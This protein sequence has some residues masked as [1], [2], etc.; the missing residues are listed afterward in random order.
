LL[1][2]LGSHAG[3]SV[4]DLTVSTQDPC[5]KVKLAAVTALGRM[6][7]AAVPAIP[8][9][10]KRGLADGAP[11]VRV[12]TAKALLE[13]VHGDH[14]TLHRDLLVKA[15]ST[16]L[17]DGETDVRRA[18]AECLRILCPRDHKE[19]CKS[20]DRLQVGVRSKPSWRRTA[21]ELRLI[22][23]AYRDDSS[24]TTDQLKMS[25]LSERNLAGA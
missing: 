6:G 16:R 2:Q 23:A 7:A 22:S 17:K 21:N 4:S 24:R 14:H 19:S 15:V 13:L 1:G 20:E 10:A 8:T 18:A 12:A 25:V 3:P 5:I 9:L 11:S